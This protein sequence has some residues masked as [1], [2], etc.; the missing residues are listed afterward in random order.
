M[1][2]CKIRMQ[3]CAE[4]CR[5]RVE[6]ALRVWAPKQK[7]T[8]YG[9]GST[10]GALII[11]IGFW[12]ILHDKCKKDPQHSISNYSGPYIRGYGFNRVMDAGTVIMGHT[13]VHAL[14]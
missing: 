13:S 8:V 9:S 12:G 4:S 3:C 6:D 11:R 14:F 7:V 5:Q 1:I 2:L 10:T